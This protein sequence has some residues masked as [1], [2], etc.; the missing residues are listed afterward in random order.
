[1]IV[2]AD[3]QTDS[4]EIEAR[5]PSLSPWQNVAFNNQTLSVILDKRKR[6]RVTVTPG[7]TGNPTFLGVPLE[8]AFPHHL[9]PAT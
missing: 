8:D 6:L 4:H 9:M 2:N 5:E 1:M 7:Q 3:G